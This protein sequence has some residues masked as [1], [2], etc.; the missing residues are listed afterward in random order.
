MRV[1]RKLERNNYFYFLFILNFYLLS[2]YTIVILIFIKKYSFI[3]FQ[4]FIIKYITRS[5]YWNFIYDSYKLVLFVTIR[6]AHMPMYNSLSIIS[7]D[8]FI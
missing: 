1:T 4:E 8:L 6:T 2:Y 5:K 3:H 7:D